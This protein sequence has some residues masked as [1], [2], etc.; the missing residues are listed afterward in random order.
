MC[1]QAQTAPPKDTADLAKGL[2]PRATPADYQAQTKLG[3]L[4]LAAEFKRHSIP[5][6]E[7]SA[8]TTE[9]YVSVEVGIFGA[10]DARVKLSADEFSLRING[11]KSP[12][13][14]VPFGM[15]LAS[16][17]DPEYEVPKPAKSK[18]SGISADGGGDEK[19]D[20]DAPPP[21]IP[22]E[23]VRAM[24]LRV[25]KAAIPEGDRALPIAGLVFFQYRGRDKSIHSVELIY[26][27]GAGKA[28]VPLQ[29]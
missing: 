15:V 14:S 6:G 26:E 23:V 5:T 27:G 7:G 29:P 28:T 21:H 4:T 11:K 16:A 10:P 19:P 18:V 20:K 3:N 2:P 25:R 22:I 17:K 1:L 8:L 12:Q 24:A 13:A 9:E